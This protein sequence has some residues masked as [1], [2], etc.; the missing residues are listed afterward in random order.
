MQIAF[1]LNGRPASFDAD[2]RTLVRAKPGNPAIVGAL[3]EAWRAFLRPPW[4]RI[5]LSA[6]LSSRVVLLPC[7]RL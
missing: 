5:S 6:A 2:P 4:P 1:T 7:P 3:A